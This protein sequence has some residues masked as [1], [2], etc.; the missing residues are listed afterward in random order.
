MDEHHHDHDKTSCAGGFQMLHSDLS[1]S[2]I[3]LIKF[4]VLCVCEIKN[5]FKCIKLYLL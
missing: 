2:V 4:C 5:E 1:L 3:L